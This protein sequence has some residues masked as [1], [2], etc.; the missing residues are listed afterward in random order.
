MTEWHK[1]PENMPDKSGY[2]LTCNNKYK[3]LSVDLYFNDKTGSFE[4]EATMGWI[5]EDEA[6]LTHWA[7]LPEAP[8]D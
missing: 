3:S 7:E 1:Y 6:D 4:K 2:Y 5:V 8:H